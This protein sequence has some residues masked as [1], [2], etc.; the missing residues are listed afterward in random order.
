MSF[1]KALLGSAL[2]LPLTG[3]LLNPITTQNEGA[4]SAG[5]LADTGPAQVK[6]TSLS[7]NTINPEDLHDY[8]NT[9]IVPT[10]YV[11]LL[12]DGKAFVAKQGSGL[13]AMARGGNA[14]SV[15]A[16]A[17]YKVV[18]ID[19]AY[20]QGLARQAYDDFVAKLRAAGYTVLTYA[21]IKDRDY[22]K[23]AEREKPDAAWGLPVETPAGS[24]DTYVVAAPSDEQMF[25][26]S[27]AG[28]VFSPFIRFGKPKFTDGTVVIPQY[29]IVA[30][31]VWGEAERGY[32]RIGATIKSAPGMN[33]N[34]A[35]VP[36]MG[37][38]KVR[39][40]RGI[41][42]A[43]TKNA[44]TNISEKAGELVKS[45]DTTPTAANALSK[46]LSLLTGVGDIQTASAEYTFTIDK[47]AYAAGTLKGIADFNAALVK[48]AASK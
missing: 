17:K 27:A 15:K 31:Q 37:K 25:K 23:D 46:G 28:G 1:K 21:D 36:W 47:A 40:M 33:L 39:M 7:V 19:K 34:Y 32:N 30:P 22:V 45:A 2:V 4:P 20:A 9:L 29:T 5:R 44:V 6:T 24:S 48:A 18:G 13:Q 12:V 16:S 41:P 26:S 10:V 8:N 11:K 14:N 3:C 43:Y 35:A 42:G 38:P